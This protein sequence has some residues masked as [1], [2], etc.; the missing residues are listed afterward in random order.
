[1]KPQLPDYSLARVLVI[2]DV[3]LDRYCEGD[4]N[5]ISPEAPVPVVTVRD[6][7]DRPGGAGNVALN[8]AALGAQVSL[9]GPVGE[10]AAAEAL[11]QL[12]TG[13]GVD[14]DLG[15]QAGRDTP[16]KL[17]VIARRQQ[18]LRLDFETDAEYRWEEIALRSLRVRLGQSA[19]LLLSDYA[20]G[21]LVDPAPLMKIAAELDVPVLV[22]PKG[23]NLER[24]RG[25]AL[26][27][28]NLAE[29]EA[30]VG[31]CASESELER[32]GRELA[33]ALDIGALLITRGARGMTL[34][35]P[36]GPLRHFPASAREVFDVTGAGDTVASVIAA[37]LAAG[38]SLHDAVA[39]ANTAAAIVVAKLGAA[40][41]SVL[42]LASAVGHGAE[43]GTLSREQAV[44]AVANAQANGERVVFTNGC[45]DLLHPGHVAYLEEAKLMGDRLIVAV[46]S[47]ASV[48]RLKGPGRPVNPLERRMAVL[49][50]LETVDWVVAFD[51]DTP[52][53]LLKLLRPQV[54]AKGGDYRSL[55]EIVGHDIVTGYGGDVRLCRHVEGHSTTELV[56]RLQS[57]SKD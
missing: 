43:R 1:M 47:D 5:R 17:R 51:E 54:L 50:G 13:A 42:E 40:S 36:D 19:V 14:C 8:I 55:Q 57:V 2:G 3:L 27:T 35:E 34:L 20:K 32:K 24:Y 46:N 22:D 49:A 18:L 7:S 39:L 23:R 12:L 26:L 33:R 48:A 29:F 45:F 9:V 11:D 52:E 16:T 4:A 28:P 38:A 37:S 30:V 31:P 21:A 10:D 44:T 25:A 15:R 41:V 56:A 6:T 53:Q